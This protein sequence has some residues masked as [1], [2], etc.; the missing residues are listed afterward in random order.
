MIQFEDATKRQLL[1]IALREDCSL[2]DKYEA[3]RELQLRQ[4][5]DSM[6]QELILLYGRGN[7]PFQ[8]TI[9]LGIEEYTVR[10]KI[11]QYGLKR[12]CGA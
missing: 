10:N 6:L 3:V 2:D 8:V 12:R 11:N 7:S 9:E 1:Q 4:W 5:N